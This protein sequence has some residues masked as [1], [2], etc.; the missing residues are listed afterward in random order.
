MAFTKT[1]RHFFTFVR[2]A[3]AGMRLSLMERRKRN[4]GKGLSKF[5]EDVSGPIATPER[6]RL[7]LRTVCRVAEID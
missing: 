6:S 3:R 2:E 5:A 7:Q 1:V 4:F